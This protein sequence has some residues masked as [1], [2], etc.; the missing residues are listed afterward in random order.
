V[1]ETVCAVV[2]RV[3]T[4][5]LAI[6]LLQL[7]VGH[8]MRWDSRLG[9]KPRRNG[10]AATWENV[11]GLSIGVLNRA[12]H[13][14]HQNTSAT[15]HGS[16]KEQNHVKELKASTAFRQARTATSG[17]PAAEKA[18]DVRGHHCKC[19]SRG[20]LTS[21]GH[22]KMNPSQKANINTCLLPL[23]QKKS[24]NHP[25]NKL[26]QVTSRTSARVHKVLWTKPSKPTETPPPPGRASQPHPNQHPLPADYPFQ[27]YH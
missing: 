22:V 1:S 26:D 13:P 15:T 5:C 7:L 23:R 27:R 6:F 16:S 18:P 19:G 9:E 21:T 4:G 10:A 20:A 17:G 12:R 11:H 2:T 8:K 24:G 25:R 14:G 3:R